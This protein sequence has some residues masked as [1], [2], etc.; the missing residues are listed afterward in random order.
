MQQRVRFVGRDDWTDLEAGRRAIVTIRTTSGAV[1]TQEVQHM[2]M[3]HDELDIKFNELVTPRWG[4]TQCAR[5]TALLKGLAAAGSVK[6]LM[7]E[8]AAD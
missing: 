1:L 3:T 6:P 8:L 4:E 2:P 7:A 5:V